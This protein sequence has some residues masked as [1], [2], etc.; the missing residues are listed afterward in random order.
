LVDVCVSDEYF[1][2]HVYTYIGILPLYWI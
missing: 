1:V 2:A